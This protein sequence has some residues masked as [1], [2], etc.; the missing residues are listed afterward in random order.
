MGFRRLQIVRWRMMLKGRLVVVPNGVGRGL[1]LH[2][3]S[4]KLA[5]NTLRVM[6]CV[7]LLVA[8]ML[9][10]YTR[11]PFLCDGRQELRNTQAREQAGHSD[12][13]GSWEIRE[14]AGGYVNISI[15]SFQPLQ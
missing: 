15:P 9:C 5:F 7:V 11:A 2:K 6:M 8:T 3:A 4:S 12:G 10:V 14:E 1:F 13:N